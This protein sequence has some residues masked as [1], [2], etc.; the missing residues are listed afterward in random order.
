MICRFIV[1]NYITF[2]YIKY[3]T[4]SK[5]LDTQKIIYSKVYLRHDKSLV[6][7]FVLYYMVVALIYNIDDMN[8]ICSSPAYIHDIYYIYTA[9]Y[10]Y[11]V[12][13]TLVINCITHDP[14][15]FV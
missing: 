7:V 11:T 12:R 13:A 6:V 8:R 3:F 1:D 9:P 5:L 14:Y 4:H 10:I 2:S 15:F